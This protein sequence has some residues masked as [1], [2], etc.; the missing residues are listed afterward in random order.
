[1]TDAWAFRKAQ[2][3]LSRK[4]RGSSNRRRQMRVAN[5]RKNFLHE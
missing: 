5:A 3:N 4:K 2:R 1:V